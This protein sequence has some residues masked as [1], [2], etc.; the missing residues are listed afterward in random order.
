MIRDD[1]LA[2]LLWLAVLVTALFACRWSATMLD[3]HYADGVEV[4]AVLVVGAS[5]FVPL[6][7]GDALALRT[8]APAR[9]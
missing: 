5:V 9:R 4:A 7:L 3:D 2:T 1:P 8:D 6:V